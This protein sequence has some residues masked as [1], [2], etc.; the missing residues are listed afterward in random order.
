M[1]GEGK[2]EGGKEREGNTG[3]PYTLGWYTCLPSFVVCTLAM[4]L[5]SRKMSAGPA[6]M[7]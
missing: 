2:R 1:G 4:K 3:K 5:F 6:R 7:V